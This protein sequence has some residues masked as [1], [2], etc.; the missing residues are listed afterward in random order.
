VNGRW[1]VLARLQAR[2][3]FPL[4]GICRDLDWTPTLD[5][6]DRI[7]ALH[8]LLR[9][10]D[11]QLLVLVETDAAGKPLV[12]I[13]PDTRLVFRFEIADPSFLAATNLDED[14]LASRRFHFAN[15]G[16][17]AAVSPSVDACPLPR[18]LSSWEAARRYA[19]GALVRRGGVTYECLRTHLNEP[20]VASGSAFWVPKAAAHYASGGDLV[21][22]RPRLARFATSAPVAVHRV[23][24]L[25]LETATGDFTKVLRDA[26]T[27]PTP[28][29]RTE[30]VVDLTPWPAGRYRVEID[31]E[32]FESW[33]DDAWEGAFGVVE[34]F[35]HLPATDPFALFDAAG[36]ARGPTY[37]LPF[38]NRRAYRKYLTPQHKVGK[39]VLSSDHDLLGP[40]VPGSF[41]PAVPARRDFFVSNDPLPLTEGPDEIPVALMV[42]TEAR[43]APRPDPRR[44]GILERAFDPVLG[45]HTDTTVSIRL[46]L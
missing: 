38:A 13:P 9:V 8:L 18:A 39:I 19:P 26:L 43:P 2:H 33:H 25:G 14:L 11:H 42:G 30:V 10:V 22:V 1:N 15:L 44:I 35:F 32:V 46:P 5:T 28:E 36:K 12:A 41:D 29:P 37:V 7:A 40:Y 4:D 45:V 20:P 23:R 3:E 6:A 17:S 31:G 27:E 21:A 16:G 34:L 24:V